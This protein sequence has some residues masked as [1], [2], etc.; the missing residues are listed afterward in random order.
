MGGLGRLEIA[1]SA[2]VGNFTG[3]HG[4]IQDQH[5]LAFSG[6]LWLRLASPGS[7]FHRKTNT[8]MASVFT[9]NVCDMDPGINTT[10]Q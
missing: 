1:N 5:L 8:I 10:G 2:C 9:L 7:G 4:G 6:I 3:T